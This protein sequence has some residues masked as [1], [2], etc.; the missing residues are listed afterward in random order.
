MY[1]KDASLN[2]LAYSIGGMH[3]S[4]HYSYRSRF[5]SSRSSS[6]FYSA[7]DFFKLAT[8]HVSQKTFL[9]HVASLVH[10]EKQLKQIVYVLSRLQDIN[11]R[12]RKCATLRK[13]QRALRMLEKH[14]LSESESVQS[15]ELDRKIVY[16]FWLFVVDVCLPVQ[17]R[18]SS[19]LCHD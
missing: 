14:D 10:T 15:S 17:L 16:L 7:T 3:L 18:T 19:P 13:E 1:W 9:L 5:S 8:F 12:L 2:T 6:R 11:R 4:I